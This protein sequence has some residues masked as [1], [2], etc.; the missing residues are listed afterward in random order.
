MLTKVPILMF[1]TYRG[2][3]FTF[4]LDSIQSDPMKM[5]MMIMIVVMICI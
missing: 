3:M 5:A 2:A 1:T 4:S